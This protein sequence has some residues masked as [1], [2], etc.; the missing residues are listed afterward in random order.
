[1]KFSSAIKA[2]A[3]SLVLLMAANTTVMAHCQVPCGIYGDQ[4]QIKQLQQHITTIKKS[5]AQITELSAQSPLNHNQIV[6]WV[7]TKEDHAQKIQD[8]ISA[9]WLTQRIKP[10]DENDKAAYANYLNQCAMLRQILVY[11]MKCKQTLDAT[12]ADKMSK[13]LDAFAA[14][15]FDKDDLKHMMEHHKKES[16]N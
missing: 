12:H 5:M 10:A 4:L 3:L 11:A 6:R 7:N 16:K 13:T 2:L 14:T 15:Y 8:D 9:Y 1:M